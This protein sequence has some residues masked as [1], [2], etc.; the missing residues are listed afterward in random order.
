MHTHSFLSSHYFYTIYT[1]KPPPLNGFYSVSIG[2][3]LGDALQENKVLKRLNVAN[4]SIDSVACLTICA[5]VLENEVRET[6]IF[7][8][9]EHHVVCT[10]YLYCIL[11]TLTLLYYTIQAL[12]HVVFDGNPIGEQGAKTLMVR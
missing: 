11:Y 2:M 8:I 3:A 12:E 6:T 9:Q 4:N 5:G 10:I 7:V 1:I